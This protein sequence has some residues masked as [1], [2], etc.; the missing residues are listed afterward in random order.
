[1]TTGTSDLGPPTPP[2]PTGRPVY[3]VLAFLAGM[4]G[5]WALDILVA[6]FGM[7]IVGKSTLVTGTLFAVVVCALAVIL[8]RNEQRSFA[9]GFAVGYAC[10]TV[11]SAGLCTFWR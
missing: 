5:F 11:L 7:G 9:A 3:S 8:Y 2:T 6:L 10:L 1:M 4:F